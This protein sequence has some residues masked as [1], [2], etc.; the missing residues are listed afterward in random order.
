MGVVVAAPGAVA[1]G[2][3]AKLAEQP[4]GVYLL[5]STELWERFSYYGMLGLMVLFMV[6]PVSAGGFGW[7]NAHALRVFGL[8]LSSTWLAPLFGGWVA[9]RLTGA[10]RAVILGCA[11]LALGN[12]L[13]AYCALIPAANDNAQG[14]S[15]RDVLLYAGLA[16][17]VIGAGLFKSNVSVLMGGLFPQQDDPRRDFGFTVFFMGINV[18][19]L[20][21]P[22][23]AGTLGERVGW[24]WG[25]AV[26]GLGMLIGIAIFLKAQ[27]ALGNAGLSPGGKQAAVVRAAT[28]EDIGRVVTIGI[29]GIF[30]TVFAVGLM[31]Y[32]GLLNLFTAQNIDRTVDGFE[33]PVTWFLTLNPL[34]IVLLGPLVASYWDGRL[35][36]R[37]AASSTH[38]FMAGL[39]LMS[40]AFGLIGIAAAGASANSPPSWLWIVVFYFLLTIGELCI[41]P[42]GLALVSRLAPLRWVGL[43][44]GAWLLTN[45]L[46]SW[47]AGELG[48]WAQRASTAFVFGALALVA[49]TAAAAL[50]TLRHRLIALARN[51]P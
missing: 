25:F 14:L 28:H 3:K 51:I 31:Q 13:L 36:A 39:L 44:M 41:S 33:I 34:F 27:K 9:D 12:F 50:W 10:R 26:S 5:F 45:A 19:A 23:I 35:R 43:L 42:V 6:A 16:W 32:G 30:A 17:M 47:I 40:A 49:A 37:R 7:D 20:L 1:P 46:G 48:V 38:K 8:F 29:F 15:F 11:S 22:L 2:L 18:G 4:A 21:A 24:H